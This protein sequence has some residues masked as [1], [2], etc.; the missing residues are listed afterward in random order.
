[1]INIKNKMNYLYADLLLSGTACFLL[2]LFAPTMLYI[3]NSLD[4][5]FDIFD[6]WKHMTLIAVAAFV[7]SV[8]FLIVSRFINAKFHSIVIYIYLSIITAMI[9][10]GTLLSGNIPVLDGNEIDWSS[11][12]NMR[13]ASAAVWIVCFILYGLL[14]LRGKRELLLK[15]SASVSGIFLAFLVNKRFV[16]N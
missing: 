16:R 5:S 14:L 8:V 11:N 7:F 15:C 9:L 12:T 4:F 2:L 3:N 6:V 1:M 13:V 10:Q